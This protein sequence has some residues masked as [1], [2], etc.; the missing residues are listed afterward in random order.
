MELLHNGYVTH[1][2]RCTWWEGTGSCGR[3][4]LLVFVHAELNMS[5]RFPNPPSGLI[6]GAAIP[7]AFS[8]LWQ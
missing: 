4:L 6:A 8:V 1:G 2:I 5:S 3:E 7:I